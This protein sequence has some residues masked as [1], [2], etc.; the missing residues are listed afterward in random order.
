MGFIDSILNLVCALLWFNWRSLRYAALQKSSPVSLAATLKKAGPRQRARW[1]PLFS[2]FAL[3]GARGLF[4][5]NVGSA[6]NW[7]P[8][9]A[10]GVISLP[11]RSDYLGRM[12]LFS[13]LSF[14]LV[15]A[16][17]YAWLLLI[18]IIN[19]DLP[20]DEPVQKLVRWHLGWVESWPFWLKLLLPLILTA[21]IWGLANASLVRLG[22]VPAPL[23]RLHLWQ[24]ALLLGLNSLLGWKWLLVAICALYLVN[25]YVYLGNSYFWTYVN[26]T[27]A[28]LLV[29]VR[30]LPLRIGKADFSPVLAMAV[31]LALADWTTRWLSAIFQRLPY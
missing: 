2:L 14:A 19:R 5:W 27:G 6:L 3:L 22:M 1:I 25:N 7:T 10:L 28:N 8:S 29:P 31:V 24:Q 21:L 11:F 26:L 9:L 13:F 17:L 18:S 15:L 16:L 4:Y 20:T 23:S 30:R 12:L